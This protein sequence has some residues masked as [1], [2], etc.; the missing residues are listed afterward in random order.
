MFAVT[1]QPDGVVTTESYVILNQTLPDM[2]V[3][4][5]CI[6]VRLF[7]YRLR[8]VFVSYSQPD[9][10]NHIAWNYFYE[11]SELDL[12]CCN[13]KVGLLIPIALPL[14]RWSSVC[15]AVDLRNKIYRVAGPN[16]Y[17]E[18]T[19]V[20]ADGSSDIPRIRGG[21][22][23]YLGQ[24]Q[25]RYGGGFNKFQSL[26]AT[27]SEMAIFSDFL[28]RS[29]LEDFVRCSR[30]SQEPELILPDPALNATARNVIEMEVKLEEVCEDT[31][32]YVVVFPE[33]RDFNDSVILC[34]AVSGHLTLPRDEKENY[35]LFLLGNVYVEECGRDNT[36][37]VW[38]GIRGDEAAGKWH[39]YLNHTDLSFQSFLKD[40]TP[41]APKT[42]ATMYTS[43]DGDIEYYH[44]MWATRDCDI[45]RRCLACEYNGV[46][47]LHLRGLCQHS[48]F[49]RLYYVRDT[50]DH[51]PK[52]EGLL[53]SHIFRTWDADSTS[54]GYWNLV[55]KGEESFRARTRV[56]ST[57][58]YPI[59]LREWDVSG[60]DC[61]GQRKFLK[62]T[63]CKNH[64]F[65]CN[66]GSCVP[67]ER[68]CDSTTQ[69][70]DSSDETNCKKLLTP[71]YYQSDLPPPSFTEGQALTMH[72]AIDVGNIRKFDTNAFSFALDLETTLVWYD[73]QVTYKNLKDRLNSNRLES[74]VDELWTPRLSLFGDGMST[75][76]LIDRSFDLMVHKETRPMEDNDEN[77]NE[78][79]MYSGRTNPLVSRRK[80]FATFSCN[81]DLTLYPFD[82]QHCN[83]HV[84]LVNTDKT[85]VIL[86]RDNTSLHLSGKRRLLEY[87]VESLRL[88][89][90]EDE[91]YS[92]VTVL[93]TFSNLYRFHISNSYVPTFLLLVISYLTFHF[94]IDSFNERIMV[95]LTA[96]LVASALFTQVSSF[97]PKTA[98]LKM[99]DVWFIFCISV[100]FGI[101]VAVAGINRA[102]VHGKSEGILTTKVTQVYPA[103]R[104]PSRDFDDSSSKKDF[105]SRFNLWAQVGFPTLVISFVF[106]YGLVIVTWPDT[107]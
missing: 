66:D 21:G 77:A 55:V 101:V 107:N 24:D 88:E 71:E 96:L 22:L 51:V 35:E 89:D 9:D 33:L 58:E 92:G 95:S 45:V 106:V 63:S 50:Q 39:D 99:I 30:M 97:V 20:N 5:I 100:M 62:L 13:G 27:L 37:T 83:I 91:L 36:D 46:K 48:F 65:T 40:P 43:K 16:H 60:D 70:P 75:S 98:Y 57:Y 59:G 68:R 78:D 67:I 72:I 41:K 10:D 73:Q 54:T 86:Q 90:G 18:K 2:N 103:G 80:V 42:C 61:P 31:G 69:C 28:Q 11:T 17:D 14:D 38:L 85:F 105:S 76:D 8:A 79:E 23:L 29:E 102:K 53:Y 25:D 32:K 81:F 52:F 12:T 64:E 49:D 56:L 104:T 82:T 3:F 6:R 44:G 74:S 19:F 4:T 84:L 15:V 93:L 47:F 7:Q 87:E 1:L 26:Y 94:D 34:H